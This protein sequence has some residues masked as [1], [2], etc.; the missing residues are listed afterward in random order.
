MGFAEGLASA[1]NS[2]FK[3]SAMN[4][5][6]AQDKEDRAWQKM[7]RERQ[8]SQFAMEDMIDNELKAVPNALANRGGKA[9]DTRNLR[10]VLP[11]MDEQAAGE[12]SEALK[13]VKDPKQIT[14][15]LQAY[16]P[17]YGMPRTAALPDNMAPS[18]PAAPKM[19]SLRAY[20]GDDGQ[21]YMTAD[22]EYKP[23]QSEIMLEQARRLTSGKF[24]LQG[25]KQGTAMM[26]E[27]REM[28]NAERDQDFMA[29]LEAPTFG[30]KVGKLLD[31]QNGNPLVPGKVDIQRSEDGKIQLVHTVPGRDKP[32]V[33]VIKGDS[34]EEMVT[35]LAMKI[36]ARTNPDIWFRL[37]DRRMR[38]QDRKED[39]EIRAQERAEDREW[40]ETLRGD[41]L[42]YRQHQMAMDQK[43]YGLQAAEAAD[44]RR[45]RAAAG[46]AMT[47][48]QKIMQEAEYILRAGMAKTPQEAMQ[49]AY[50]S[51]VMGTKAFGGAADDGPDVP[52]D[53]MKAREQF[54]LWQMNEGAGAP[55]AEVA[56]RARIA[57]LNPADVGARVPP[58]LAA[59]AAAAKSMKSAKPTP[60]QKRQ[61]IKTAPA[62]RKPTVNVASDPIVQSLRAT[63]R[64]LGPVANTPKG[65]QQLQAVGD[66]LN[67]RIQQIRASTDPHIQLI[68]Q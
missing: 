10:D 37:E 41:D 54:R 44:A 17:Q 52:K 53:I 48:Q 43:R 16:Q 51:A 61:A 3:F 56:R 36:R 26:K 64:E 22:P 12:L 27:A 45:A 25:M 30:E 32:H 9:I 38:Q 68:D 5:Q 33:T 65:A 6:M 49:L 23:R 15:A 55:E 62:A 57:G 28:I 21:T 42:A 58:D 60:T 35:D 1:V 2:Y 24:G 31:I 67:K 14:A 11:G 63:A 29:A 4:D 13:S 19:P 40:K 50:K 8:M 66:A 7:M 39:R 18:E 47:P 46:K 20:K 59:V 34:E